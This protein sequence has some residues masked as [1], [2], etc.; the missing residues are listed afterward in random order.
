MNPYYEDDL[1]TLY[2]GDCRE[3]T[4]WLDADVLVTDPPY[5]VKWVSGITSYDGGRT[6]HRTTPIAGDESTEARDAVLNA[7]SRKPAPRLRL[8]ARR[9]PD[10]DA[11]PPHLAQA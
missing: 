10:R 7:W 5:G 4:A 1:V 9:P 6:N 8:L 2:H 11:A 3:V